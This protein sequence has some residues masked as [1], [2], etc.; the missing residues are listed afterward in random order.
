MRAE[1]V[2][3]AA[4]SFQIGRLVLFAGFNPVFALLLARLR[5]S[6]C[7]NGGGIMFTILSG[8]NH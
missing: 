1:F 2:A 6:R 8:E 4:C 3:H 7:A 5:G